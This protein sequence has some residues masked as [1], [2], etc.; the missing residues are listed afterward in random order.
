MTKIS[1]NDT[2]LK[3]CIQYPEI[4]EIM[5][6]LGFKDIVKPGMIQS[7]GR[8]MTIKKGSE[9]KKINMDIIAETF[10]NYNFELVD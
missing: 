1:I 9:M 7:V 3:I 2:I 4:K 6:E 8:F 10:K 5:K